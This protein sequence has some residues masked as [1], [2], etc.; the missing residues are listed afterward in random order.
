MRISFHQRLF[1]VAVLLRF[2]LQA[3]PL[4]AQGPAGAPPAGGAA[5][6]LGLEGTVE[7]QRSE[8]GRWDP[9]YTNQVLDAGNLLRTD[10]RSQALLRYSDLETFVVGP[11]SLM[12]IEGQPGRRRA[13]DLFKGLLYLFHRDKPERLDVRSPKMAAIIRGTE[14]VLEVAD[15]G[16]TTLS[17]IDGAVSISNEFGQLELASGEQ[18]RVEPGKAPVRTARLDA[19]SVIQWCLYYPAVLDLDELTFTVEERQALSP[20]MATW[21]SGD[22]L[23]ALAAY[24]PERQPVSDEEKVYLAALLLS[25]GEVREGETLLDTLSGAAVPANRPMVIAGALRQLI[26]VVKG[27]SRAAKNAPPGGDSSSALLAESYFEQSRNRLEDA[28]ALAR[29]AV[30]RSPN[31]SFGWTRV[32][33]LEFSFGRI[34]AARDALEKS[35]QLAPRNAQAMALKGFL[36][37]ARNRIAEAHAAFDQAIGIDPGLGNG[38]LGRGLCRIRQGQIEA[39]RIDLQTAATVEPNRAALRSYLGKAFGEV[40]DGRAAARELDLARQLDANDPTAWLYSA[41]LKR[42]ENRPNEAVRDLEHSREL[43]AHRQVY[44]SRLLLDQDQAVRGANLATLYEDAGMTDVSVREA[45]RAVGTDYANFSAHL[46]LADSYN[47]MRDP[48]Q[49]NLRYETPWLSEYLVA[50]LLAPVGAGTLSPYVTQQEYARLFERNRLGLTS[51]TEYRSSGDW[52]QTAAQYGIYDNFSYAAEVYYRSENGDRPNSDLEQLSATLRLKQ[53]FTPQDGLFFQA[54][55][56]N[57]EAGDVAPY[58]RPSE[59]NHS[60]RTEETQKPILVA[61]FHHQWAPGVDTLWLAGRVDGTYDAANP[62]QPTLV[63]E[64]DSSGATVSVHPVALGQHYQAEAELYTA[65]VQQIFQRPGHTLLLGGRFQTGEF[66]AR[67]RPDLDSALLGP[68]LMDEFFAP[69]QHVRSDFARL[70]AYGY[71]HLQPIEPLTLIAGVSYDHLTYPVNFRY[72]PL[73]SGEESAGQWSPKLGLIWTPWRNTTLR[74]AYTQSRGGVAYDQSFQLEPTQVAGF[75]QAW[76]SII[77]EAV[78]GANSAPRFEVLGAALDHRFDT[79]TY[80]G[81][82]LE[83]L[84]SGVH[85]TVGVY[86]DDSTN[87]VNPI[88]FVFPAGARQHFD[89]DERS[90]TLALNQLVDREW[91]FG[92]RYRLSH[93]ELQESFPDLVGVPGFAARHR[94]EALLHQLQLDAIYTHPSGGFGQAQGVWTAQDNDG[95]TPARPG[96][97]FWQF[98][99][100]V[101]YRF[102]RRW[103]EVRVGLLNVADQDY[104]LNPLSL[105]T[106]MPRERTFVAGLKFNF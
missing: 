80:L 61:G 84:R 22:L 20:S 46:F 24:P 78:T 15:D 66:T 28:L 71:Y 97:D 45:S 18:G 6:I 73:A 103:A 69:T 48:R 70:N 36:L 5:V 30:A 10:R 2:F 16:T 104:R 101:G 25:V 55:W 31:F 57:A 79:G 60:L 40:G 96:D 74:A 72:A 12:R 91:S 8:A 52:L 34:K 63:L 94:R 99:V 98:N 33:E 76:R 95:Y 14:F 93:A 81:V 65:E 19:A 4:L 106:L 88:P 13:L 68:Y 26:A 29:K 62:Q 53:Q 3:E 67:N 42:Q 47:A 87:F 23:K 11:R 32:S 58:Y 77:P 83:W 89:Y 51:A 56:Y 7:V 17:L 9:A 43:N 105:T 82:N 100:W 102:P 85:R 44:R 21:R 64:K 41:L 39:G 38:W 1:A 27:S 50:N 35:L 92:A 90:F 86:N 75:N 37:A 59:A 49:I 54:T